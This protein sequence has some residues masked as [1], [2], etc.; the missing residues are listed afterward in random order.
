MFTGAVVLARYTVSA[1]A[2]EER[3]GVVL[4]RAARC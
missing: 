2:A 3:A 1:M 4:A